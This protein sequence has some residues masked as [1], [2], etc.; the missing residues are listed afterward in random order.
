MV[1]SQIQQASPAAAQILSSEGKYDKLTEL[2]QSLG[3]SIDNLGVGSQEKSDLLAEM[4]TIEAQIAEPEPSRDIL[5]RCVQSI[6]GILEVAATTAIA[7]VLLEL[8]KGLLGG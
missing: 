3:D 1:D 8:F 4:Q 7:A 5:T 6:I 2:V